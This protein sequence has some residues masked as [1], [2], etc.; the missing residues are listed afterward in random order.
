[1]HIYMEQKSIVDVMDLV[2]FWC[3]SI[4]VYN[5]YFTV[6]FCTKSFNYRTN[7]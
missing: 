4:F 2:I 6:Y 7:S 3:V 1:M 5:V